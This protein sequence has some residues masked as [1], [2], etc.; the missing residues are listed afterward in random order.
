MIFFIYLYLWHATWLISLF[1]NQPTMDDIPFNDMMI[2]EHG[3]MPKAAQHEEIKR[4]K[5]AFNQWVQT[6][7]TTFQTEV[8]NI[9]WEFSRWG[10][11][12]SCHQIQKQVLYCVG[13]Q[14]KLHK[15]VIHNAWAQAEALMEKI[16]SKCTLTNSMKVSENIFFPT[17]GN[18]GH[19]LIE[20]WEVQKVSELHKSNL[21][22]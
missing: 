21:S 14:K 10:Y 17:S 15:P 3:C 4:I 22:S 7:C 18:A 1:G 13:M 8:D 6:L 20:L 5:L 2:P 19:E 12:C 16:G 11:H 9:A